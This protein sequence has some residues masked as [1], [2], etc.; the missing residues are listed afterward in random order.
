VSDRAMSDATHVAASPAT[1]ATP[2]MPSILHFYRPNGAADTRQSAE[3]HPDRVGGVAAA[4]CGPGRAHPAGCRAPATDTLV[5][6]LARPHAISE[7][8]FGLAGTHAM[9]TQADP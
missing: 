6:A 5:A 4:R 1:S 8:G 3:V 2:S 7:K 9:K